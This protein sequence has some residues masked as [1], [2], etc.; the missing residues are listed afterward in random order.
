MGVGRSRSCAGALSGDRAWAKWWTAGSNC[1]FQPPCMMHHHLLYLQANTSV[2]TSLTKAAYMTTGLNDGFSYADKG[3]GLSFE[4]FKFANRYS[5]SEW[6]SVTSARESKCIILDAPVCF[7]CTCPTMIILPFLL[8]HPM[9]L[10]SVYWRSWSPVSPTPL[11]LYL[12][13]RARG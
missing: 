8:C 11:S 3:H 5:S 12:Q 9:L 4:H 7:Q 2:E 13:I 6:I 1:L 10:I